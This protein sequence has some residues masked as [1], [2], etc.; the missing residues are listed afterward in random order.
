MVLAAKSFH[1]LVLRPERPGFPPEL[2][3]LPGMIG[4]PSFGELTTRGGGPSRH[5]H[6]ASSPARTSRTVVCVGSWSG[7][8]LSS[9]QRR[10]A[11]RCTSRRPSDTHS[12]GYAGRG[13]RRLL[14]P[15]VRAG[16]PASRSPASP[17]GGANRYSGVGRGSRSRVRR[18]RN[19]GWHGPT[20]PPR[21][22]RRPHGE[23]RGRHAT[24]GVSG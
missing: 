9:R 11:S 4:A 18:A 12:R 21:W 22:A 8:T 14:L 5:F 16:G 3:G 15:G 2:S 24:L 10:H 17:P 7:V 1:A 6:A 13:S 23:R 20:I 19:R